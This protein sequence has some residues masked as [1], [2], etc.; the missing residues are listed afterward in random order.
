MESRSDIGG[1]NVS[2]MEHCCDMRSVSEQYSSG[3]AS[4]AEKVQMVDNM[5]RLVGLYLYH[6]TRK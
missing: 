3:H 4:E 6:Q 1:D 2:S 5:P